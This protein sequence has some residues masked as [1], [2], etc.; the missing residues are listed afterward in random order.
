[1]SDLIQLVYISR[2][3]FQTVPRNDVIAPE[4]SKILR[5]S[6]RN[7]RAKQI[8]GALYFG[9]GFFFQC[10]EGSEPALMA[11]YE[12]LKTDPRHRD[13]RILSKRAITERSFGNWEMKYLPP[14]QDVNRLMQSFGMSS[15]DPYQFNESKTAKMLDMLASG[16]NLQLDEAAPAQPSPKLV[17][18]AGVSGIRVVIAVLLVLL[19]AALLAQ[20]FL[21]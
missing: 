19:L 5:V 15:F 20:R 4:V 10:L 2:A 1:M 16:S 21:S 11:L 7:N 17:T 14:E 18:K 12:T 3:A 8:V 9:N 13:L 6:R